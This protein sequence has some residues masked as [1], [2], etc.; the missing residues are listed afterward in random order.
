[1]SARHARQTQR[2]AAEDVREHVVGEKTRQVHLP[3][4]PAFLQVARSRAS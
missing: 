2:D 4:H 3:L 1:M